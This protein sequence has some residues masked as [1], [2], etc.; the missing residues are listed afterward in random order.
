MQ[1]AHDPTGYFYRSRELGLRFWTTGAASRRLIN[2]LRSQPIG[3]R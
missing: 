1:S 3:G 2:S